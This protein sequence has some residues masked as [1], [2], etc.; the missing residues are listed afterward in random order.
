M[1]WR[2][3]SVCQCW[4]DDHFKV[5]CTADIWWTYWRICLLLDFVETE[6]QNLKKANEA[7][8]FVLKAPSMRIQIPPSQLNTC[9]ADL[10]KPSNAG[11][12]SNFNSSILQNSQI[13]PNEPFGI[14]FAP[15]RCCGSSSL[16][17]RSKSAKRPV[18][19]QG[20]VARHK[21]P[22]DGQ[23]ICLTTHSQQKHQKLFSMRN[24]LQAFCPASEE[25]HTEIACALVG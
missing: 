19:H 4:P 1:I 16:L 11:N 12:V 17:D 24:H 22:W 14:Q 20:P 13:N 25:N 5:D 10:H 8:C 21:P 15:C 18:R 6:A 23:V 3:D 7:P 2:W 9:E